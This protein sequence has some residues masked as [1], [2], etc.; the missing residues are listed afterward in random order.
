MAAT[1]ISFTPSTSIVSYA[2]SCKMT[3]TSILR[4]MRLQD[5]SELRK[6]LVVRKMIL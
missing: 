6:V 5:R 2:K 3:C 1:V 4:N